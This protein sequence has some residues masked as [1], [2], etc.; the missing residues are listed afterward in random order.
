M[1]L[2]RPRWANRAAPIPAE[3]TSNIAPPGAV[4]GLAVASA[5]GARLR[6]FA[7]AAVAGALAQLLPAPG[8]VSVGA[9]FVGLLGATPRWRLARRPGTRRTAAHPSRLAELLGR[10]EPRPLAARWCS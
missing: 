7:V 9:A 5:V 8:P 2:A 6:P 10:I 4:V 3:G 1:S